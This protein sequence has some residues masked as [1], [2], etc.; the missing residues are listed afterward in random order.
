MLNA[1]TDYLTKRQLQ[2]N[3][4][5]NSDSTKAHRSAICMWQP[6]FRT[7]TILLQNYVGSRH[8]S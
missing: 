5:S 3:P 1:K 4:D 6:K 8:K 2:S 7:Y